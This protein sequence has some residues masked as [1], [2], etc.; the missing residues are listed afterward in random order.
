LRLRQITIVGLGLIGGSLAARCRK[1]FPKTRIVGV[2]RNRQALLKAKK[3]RWIH[4]G[5]T[6]LK[7]GLQS[8]ELVVL[9]TPVDTLKDLLKRIERRATGEIV[10]TDAGSVKGFLVRWAD[11]QRWRHVRFVGA[12]PLAGSHERGINAAHP[13][14]FDHS[15]TF[16]TPGRAVSPQ[17][18]RQVKRFWSK[19]SHRVVVTSPEKHD[20]VTAQIS[21]FPHL[22]ASLLVAGTA[23]GALPFA[24]SGFLDTTRIAQGDPRLWTPIFNENRREL[25]RALDR[26]GFH[27]SRARRMIQKGSA[28]TLQQF[29]RQVQ[30]R[31]AAL[32]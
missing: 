24:A 16:V 6:D 12:H 14:L 8:A 15:L 18:L 25:L 13:R 4:E 20:E 23:P 9:C 1:T 17:A 5:T 28:K 2:T 19:I 30:R 26:F 3:E 22:L 32:E 10:V 7:R 11:R 21:H 31:R 29:L 27:L